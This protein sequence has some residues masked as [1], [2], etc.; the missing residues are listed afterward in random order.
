[1]VL[2]GCQD[3][4][5]Q[6]YG[7]F[8]SAYSTERLV[9]KIPAAT[10]D[11]GS[12][13]STA[14]FK[15][16]VPVDTMS[17]YKDVEIYLN[18]QAY[19]HYV[20][21]TVYRNELFFNYYQHSPFRV[22]H[23]ED[24]DVLR[25][26]VFNDENEELTNLAA[27]HHRQIAFYDYDEDCYRFK[28]DF[29]ESKFSIINALDTFYYSR[30]GSYRGR[31]KGKH[32]D[33]RINKG[34]VLLNKPKYRHGDTLK[35]AAYLKRKN[36]K[37]FTK[38]LQAIISTGYRPYSYGASQSVL[39]A[40]SPEKPGLYLFEMVIS[41]TLQLDRTYYLHLDDGKRNSS[42]NLMKSFKVEDY[43]LDE[44]RT[45]VR[46]KQSSIGT[47]GPV[48]FEIIS[49][50]ANGQGLRGA[51]ARVKIS[52]ETIE[53][54]EDSNLYL[55]LLWYDEEVALDA[56][57]TTE[58]HID[59]DKLPKGVIDLRMEI[60]V[61]NASNETR[62]FQRSIYKMNRA[63]RQTGDSLYR[64]VDRTDHF[65][66]KALV[67]AFAKRKCE[68]FWVAENGDTLQTQKIS[69]ANQFNWVSNAKEMHLHFQ[70]PLMHNG[71]TY[72]DI[73]VSLSEARSLVFVN[74]SRSDTVC[75]FHLVNNR[76]LK[77]NYQLYEGVKLVE[78]GVTEGAKNWSL[79]GK[80]KHGF[81]L[82]VSYGWAGTMHEYT[83]RAS[84]NTA[85]LTVEV[86]APKKSFPGNTETIAVDVKDYKGQGVADADVVAFGINDNFQM[87][88][89]DNFG[90]TSKFS[91]V[92]FTS[93]DIRE[94]GGRFTSRTLGKEEVQK[95]AVGR[96]IVLPMDVS[97]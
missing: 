83:K 76:G 94:L 21:V 80:D 34:I 71:V 15:R 78:T 48:D 41:D 52:P 89:P 30:T 62:T 53:N 35:M 54:L 31:E 40:L 6:E 91:E 36:G 75:T 2:L 73:V 5:S 24:G 85:R 95:I 32:Q 87:R 18:N 3:L 38:D 51:T 4:F 60:V 45:D 90:Y 26:R 67:E 56:S 20:F 68:A 9:Y 1:M 86:K 13:I 17:I 47:E 59:G 37:A 46:V 72:E 64:F 88:M 81:T 43:R 55:P 93:S 27:V 28:K 12:Y 50:D 29:Q 97:R 70:D 16:A 23:I 7:L 58:V 11:D 74:S 61:T 92:D 66:L 22:A 19:G 44:S 8:S 39:G 84:I 10:A 82:R 57:G 63:E 25:F 96:S 65:E 79:H 69:T 49:K 14:F 33:E 77:V 42:L